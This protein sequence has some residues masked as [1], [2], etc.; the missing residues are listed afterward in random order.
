MLALKYFH[1]EEWN[2]RILAFSAVISVMRCGNSN[3]QQLAGW[4]EQLIFS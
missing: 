1:Q 4:A 2:S 3:F